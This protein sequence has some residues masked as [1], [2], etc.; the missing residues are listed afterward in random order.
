MSL[1]CSPDIPEEVSTLESLQWLAPLLG[2]FFFQIT[3]W[4]TS[5]WSF[6]SFKSLL[7]CHFLS[8]AFPNPFY[9]KLHMHNQ[10]GFISLSGSYV[11]LQHLSP[12]VILYNLLI[13]YGYWLFSPL[14]CNIW[15][16]IDISIVSGT[17]P[18][19]Y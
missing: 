18:D 12:S 5:G 15:G 14:E 19:T 3:T 9:S 1:C 7:K 17:V 16:I 2:M 13:Y 4:L 11:S 10:H 6:I 8:E